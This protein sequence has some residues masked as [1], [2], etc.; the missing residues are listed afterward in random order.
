MPCT[1]RAFSEAIGVP[2][3][4][5]LGKLLAMG[6]V[7]AN[8]NA[9]LSMETAELL[10]VELGAEVDFR[11]QVALEEKVIP[12]L[13]HQDDAADLQPRPP[14]VTSWGTSTMG[15]RRFWTAL[16]AFTWRIAKKAALPS[17]S[18]PTASTK[19][20]ARSPS[21]TR[22]AMKRLPKC[23]PRGQCDRHRRAGRGRRR[24][25]DAADRR[26]HQPCAGGRCA[27]RRGPEQDR[28]ARLRPARN[29]PATGG[30]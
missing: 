22:P 27:D 20:V 6:V 10:A 19:T 9:E 26:G 15:R 8:I 14:I 5:V 4:L 12:T 16:S 21:S 13:Q 2:A 23:A 1:V 25:R 11:R 28:S 29:P 7:T 3:R 24:R 17:T 18:A 30:Q